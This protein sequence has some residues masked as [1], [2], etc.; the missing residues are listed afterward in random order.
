[1]PG[2]VTL[3]LPCTMGAAVTVKLLEQDCRNLCSTFRLKPFLSARENTLTA[4]VWI[5]AAS[6]IDWTK[7]TQPAA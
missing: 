7:R 2:T 3:R 5:L 4:W 1:M 6:E